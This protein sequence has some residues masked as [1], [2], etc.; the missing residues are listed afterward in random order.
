V[1]VREGESRLYGA[2]V[3]R[4][5]SEDGSNLPHSLYIEAFK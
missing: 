5:E 3:P 2:N 1:E 4:Y